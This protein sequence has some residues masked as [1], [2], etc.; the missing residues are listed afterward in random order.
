MKRQ[1]LRQLVTDME[2]F[3]QC[4]DE[5]GGNPQWCYGDLALDMAKAARAVYDSCMAGQKHLRKELADSNPE[6][7][8]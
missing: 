4:C 7:T 6:H 3:L 5:D 8:K 1:H 2:A